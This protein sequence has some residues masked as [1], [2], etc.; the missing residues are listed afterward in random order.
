MKP[1]TK[2]ARRNRFGVSGE[3]FLAERGKLFTPSL[4]TG[5]LAGTMR[6]FVLENETGFEIET[7]LDALKMRTRFF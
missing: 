5:C 3:Y 4:E 7:G 6:E 1:S 2:R